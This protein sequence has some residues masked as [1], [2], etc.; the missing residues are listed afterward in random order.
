MGMSAS[1]YPQEF[2]LVPKMDLPSAPLFAVGGL[3]SCLPVPKLTSRHSHAC[4]L[5][6]AI[7]FISKCCLLMFFVNCSGKFRDL[8][9]LEQRVQ[10]WGLR[11]LAERV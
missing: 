5:V 10:L 8:L 2:I 11:V 7:V 1:L 9:Y 6:F 3:Y 4:V